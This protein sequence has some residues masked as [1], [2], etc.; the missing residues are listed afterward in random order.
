[1]SY[2][3]KI[4]DDVILEK[5]PTNISSE[6]TRRESEL[7]R[8]IAEVERARGELWEEYETLKAK[9]AIMEEHIK[10]K[11]KEH[12]PSFPNSVKKVMSVYCHKGRR[13]SLR[14]TRSRSKDINS[15]ME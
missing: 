12:Q 11:N 5:L 13:S 6:R 3:L 7:E 15:P 2:R 1:M 4:G 9:Y 14:A 10:N 8:E